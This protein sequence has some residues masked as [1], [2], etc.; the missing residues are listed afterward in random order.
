MSWWILLLAMLTTVLREVRL[1]MFLLSNRRYNKNLH[2][3]FQLL[4]AIMASLLLS[5]F[6]AGLK[7][8]LNMVTQMSQCRLSLWNNSTLCLCKTQSEA[9]LPDTWCSSCS[10]HMNTKCSRS[11]D[12]AEKANAPIHLVPDLVIA[13]L[14]QIQLP[15]APFHSPSQPCAQRSGCVDAGWWGGLQ[16]TN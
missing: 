8:G 5:L 4:C 13:N 10:W 14:G 7:P 11:A 16:D 9:K 1:V 12:G 15:V 2:P 6:L 3:V